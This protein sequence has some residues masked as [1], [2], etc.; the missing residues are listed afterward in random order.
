MVSYGKAT[1]FSLE[2]DGMGVGWMFS[3]TDNWGLEFRSFS[4]A[5]GYLSYDSGDSVASWRVRRHTDLKPGKD[6]CHMP[7]WVQT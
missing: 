1:D 2:S 4:L 6:M 7:A 5:R 3:P